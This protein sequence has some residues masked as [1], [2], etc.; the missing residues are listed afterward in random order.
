MV[1]DG[2]VA[3]PPVLGIKRS[4]EDA[5]VGVM[6]KMPRSDVVLRPPPPPLKMM[7]GGEQIMENA[8]M[9]GVHEGVRNQNA[10]PAP[11]FTGVRN[12]NIVT[13][14][15][16]GT[17]I[18]PPPPRLAKGV[19]DDMQQ[20]AKH[21][22]TVPPPPP[23]RVL[24]GVQR[25]TENAHLLLSVRNQ[26]DIRNQ[27]RPPPPPPNPS[28]RNA[29]TAGRHGYPPPPPPPRRIGGTSASDPPMEGSQNIASLDSVPPP[30]PP[31]RPGG[32]SAVG[33][34]Q[35]VARIEP[36]PTTPPP[37]PNLS[38]GSA[39]AAGMNS[40][41]E[42]LPPALSTAAY[43]YERICAAKIEEMQ[44]A[45][46]LEKQQTKRKMQTVA[47]IQPVPAPEKEHVQHTARNA[48]VVPDIAPEWQAVYDPS[49]GASYYKHVST[50]QVAWS[51][52]EVVPGLVGTTR[53]IVVFGDEKKG[54]I[55]K[56]AVATVHVTGKI[57]QSDKIFW[58]TKEKDTPWSFIAGENLRH[59]KGW[60]L[61]VSGMKVDEVRVLTIPAYEGYG[62]KGFKG[63]EKQLPRW[64]IPGKAT[65]QLTVELV[66]V[67]YGDIQK[68]QTRDWKP[69]SF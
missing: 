5:V 19:E 27:T 29:T 15:L 8:V 45:K 52:P 35:K 56:G 11:Q 30:P 39:P 17:T 51:L 63:K 58:D 16:R 38:M 12:E 49:F 53:Q 7:M 6:Q 32:S 44:K 21:D 42:P 36:P 9:R 2:I 67:R 46:A 23:P 69:E 4:M 61:G 10:P 43:E 57:L 64:N 68:Q 26:I 65:M 3:H 55:S 1:R 28:M 33:G 60:D 13:G 18:P 62:K 48:I 20:G 25:G 50:G 54:T 41:S 14:I 66:A 34:L 40:D 22:D 59:V 37:P 24:M 47:T 31:P